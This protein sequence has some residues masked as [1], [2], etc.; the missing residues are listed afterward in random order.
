[1]NNYKKPVVLMNEEM[2]EGVY[3]A[4]GDVANGGGLAKADCWEITAYIDQTPETG[5]DSYTIQTN[6]THLNPDRHRSGIIITYVFNQEVTFQSVGRGNLYGSATGTSISIEID[7]GTYNSNEGL[8][9]CALYV[10][11]ASGLVLEAVGWK[12]TGK[13]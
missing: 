8:G 9:A 13:N 10:T 6:G 11:S 7:I 3:A 1:M 5:R 2:A 4:S 12:C